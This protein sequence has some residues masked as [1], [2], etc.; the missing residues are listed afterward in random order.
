MTFPGPD[1]MR[2]AARSRFRPGA[3]GARNG[4]GNGARNGANGANGANGNSRNQGAFTTDDED[5]LTG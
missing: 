4:A 1:W 3:N 2:I 5:R